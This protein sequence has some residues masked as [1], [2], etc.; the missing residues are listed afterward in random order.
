[1]TQRILTAILRRR[2]EM[3]ARHVWS[4]LGFVCL[5]ALLATAAA[6]AATSSGSTAADAYQ[7]IFEPAEQAP[8][9]IDPSEPIPALPMFAYCCSA[10]HCCEYITVY[11]C[12]IE[13]GIATTSAV[14]CREFCNPTPACY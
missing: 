2:N 4:I 11:S 13:D 5:S 6:Q 7:L 14:Y 9:N 3:T 1:M 12:Y 8:S 10:V